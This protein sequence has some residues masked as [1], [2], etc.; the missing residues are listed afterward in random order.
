MTGLPNL[1]FEFRDIR[2]FVDNMWILNKFKIELVEIGFDVHTLT[3]KIDV[4]CD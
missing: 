1:K 4:L 3:F 2:I